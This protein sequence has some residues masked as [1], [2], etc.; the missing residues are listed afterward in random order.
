LASYSPDPSDYVARCR[1]CHTRFDRAK[2]G[3]V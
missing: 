1:S 3:D 2:L